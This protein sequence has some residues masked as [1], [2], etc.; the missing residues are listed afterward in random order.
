M[1]QR[2]SYCTQRAA[3]RLQ[4]RQIAEP[5]LALHS[6]QR[7]RPWQRPHKLGHQSGAR[8]FLMVTQQALHDVLSVSAR[9]SAAPADHGKSPGSLAIA[10]KFCER[11]GTSV[12]RLCGRRL[13]ARAARGQPAGLLKR[14]GVRCG[15][16]GAA[17]SRASRPPVNP[18]GTYLNKQR[19]ASAF[20]PIPRRRRLYIV[21]CSLG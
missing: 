12:V 19:F 10:L 9:S 5:S 11:R 8:T 7:R 18:V 15:P 17:S 2:T 16:P 20:R 13:A 6:E 14:P 21:L 1:A 4:S 3:A